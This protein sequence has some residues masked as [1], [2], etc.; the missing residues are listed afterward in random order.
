MFNGCESAIVRDQNWL[1]MPGG[2]ATVRD[3]DLPPQGL[4]RSSTKLLVPNSPVYSRLA[5]PSEEHGTRF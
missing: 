4:G 1:V 2:S 5:M 3:T